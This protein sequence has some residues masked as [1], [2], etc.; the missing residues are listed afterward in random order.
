V[1]RAQAPRPARPGPL[2]LL[3]IG[4]FSVWRLVFSPLVGPSCRF[5]PTCSA[6]GIEAMR[7]H[8]ALAGLW[9]T[10]RRIG[11]C[12]PWGGHGFDPVPER[13]E[14]PLGGPRSRM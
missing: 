14:W 9:L 8:G 3:F 6:Y 13:V 7:R 10:L 11:R 2:A 4:L 12:H 1:S 5:Q